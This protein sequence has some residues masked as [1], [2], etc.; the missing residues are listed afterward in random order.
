MRKYT[1]YLVTI[2][3]AVVLL[4]QFSEVRTNS[5]QPP[6]GRTGAPGEL[7]CGD[8]AA[9]HNTTPN[10]GSG[11]VM[12][13]FNGDNNEYVPGDTYQVTVTVLDPD[14]SKFGFECTSIDNNGDSA[15]IWSGEVQGNIA[16]PTAGA[17]DDRKYVSHFMADANNTW[18]VNWIAPATDIG[19]VTFYASGNAANGNSSA[20]GDEIYTTSLTINMATGIEI[21]ESGNPFMVESITHDYLNVQYY[22][23]GLNSVAFQL[24]D[25]NGKHLKSFDGNSQSPGTHSTTLDVSS[26]PQGLYFLQYVS[27]NIGITKKIIID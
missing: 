25:L 9:C 27:G 22:S 19:A 26:I 8:G 23:A 24:Y 11:S 4:F 10:T 18:I 13:S 12:L 15:G 17:V 21:I 20:T 5:I 1:I 6:A 7:T 2:C 14:A 16:F 3:T